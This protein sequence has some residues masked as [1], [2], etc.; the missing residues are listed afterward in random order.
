MQDDIKL[1]QELQRRKRPVKD[2]PPTSS[3]DRL[4]FGAVIG[5]GMGIAYGLSEIYLS[6]TSPS[7]RAPWSAWT[8][9]AFVMMSPVI[10]GIVNALPENRI[11]GIGWS[12][13]I[14]TLLFAFRYMFVLYTW[15]MLN[16]AIDFFVV[17]STIGFFV[18]FFLASLVPMTLLRWAVDEQQEYFDL[19]WHDLKRLVPISVVLGAAIVGGWIAPYLM[20]LVR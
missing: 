11:N 2:R 20:G 18:G 8:G 3:L 10:M 7:L 14:F 5:I 6:G 17:A 9:L 4:I 13:L 19:P 1:F 15:L 16:W 12:T